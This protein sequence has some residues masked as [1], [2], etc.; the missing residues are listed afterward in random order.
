MNKAQINTSILRQAREIIKSGEQNFVC[1]A[2]R[3]IKTGSVDDRAS[4]RAWVVALLDG[5]PSLE[6]WIIRIYA[7]EPKLVWTSDDKMRETRLAWIDWM[8][9]YWQGRA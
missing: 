5:S 8:I 9:T 2:I 6:D 3:K 1:L 7:Y 4:L